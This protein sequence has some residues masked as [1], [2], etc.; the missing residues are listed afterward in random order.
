VIK[1]SIWIFLVIIL[2]IPKSVKKKRNS[3]KA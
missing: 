1:E 3:V 2:I